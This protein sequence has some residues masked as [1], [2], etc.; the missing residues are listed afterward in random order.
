VSVD[1]NFEDFEFELKELFEI[2]YELNGSFDR[3]L[4]FVQSDFDDIE[5]DMLG[6]IFFKIIEVI[7]FIEREIKDNFL[8]LFEF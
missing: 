7:D 8:Q 3:S 1:G 4:G 2:F 5:V 6:E